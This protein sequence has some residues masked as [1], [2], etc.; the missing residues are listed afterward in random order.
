MTVGHAILCRIEDALLR[1]RIVVDG[2]QLITGGGPRRDRRNGVELDDLRE[3]RMR[4]HRIADRGGGF[5]CDGLEVVRE[6]EIGA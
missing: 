3:N 6:P 5:G 1:Q 2:D 4:V